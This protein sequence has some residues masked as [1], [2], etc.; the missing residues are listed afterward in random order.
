MVINVT[1][2]SRY[3]D[4]NDF[5]GMFIAYKHLRCPGR[6]F[7]NRKDLVKSFFKIVDEFLL[8]NSDNG[9]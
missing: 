7:L 8:N 9:N 6:G 2:T 3:Y 1:N 5:Q 4:S